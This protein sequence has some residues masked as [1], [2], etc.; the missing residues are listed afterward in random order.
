MFGDDDT[1]LRSVSGAW[2]VD[3]RRPRDSGINISVHREG[4]AR[5]RKISGEESGGREVVLMKRLPAAAPG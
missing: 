1:S 2:A 3:D 4:N 5:E